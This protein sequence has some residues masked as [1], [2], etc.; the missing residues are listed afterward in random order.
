[1][2]YLGDPS[3]ELC[4]RVIAAMA[5]HDPL[6]KL[7]QQHVADALH[8][9]D[10]KNRDRDGPVCYRGQ[11]AAL[12]LAELSELLDADRARKCLQVRTQRQGR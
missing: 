12:A 4:Q 1:M 5:Q 9:L 11:G 10:V 8:Q 2:S 3:A 6:L 7:L